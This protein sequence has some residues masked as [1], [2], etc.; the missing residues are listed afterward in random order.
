MATR[1]ALITGGS[2]GLGR[3]AALALADQGHDLIITYRERAGQAEEVASVAR[4]S[5]RKALAL[6]LDVADIAGHGQFAERIASV[7][8]SEWARER[9]DVLVN[10]AGI[11]VHSPFGST[12]EAQFDGLL[13]VH[14]KGPYFLTQALL[15]VIKDGG[16][17]VN[18]STGLTRF[19]IPGYAAYASMKTAMETLSRYWAKELGAR[20]IRVNTIAP[21][22]IETDF[23]A[24]A[25]EHN[26]GLKEYINSQTALGRVGRPDDIGG[27]VAFLCSDAA[28]WVNAQR[29][30]ASGGM[31]L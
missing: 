11:D 22:A 20:R 17:I 27:L 3:A 2:R 25:F 24:P 29:V 14:F 31:F 13:N 26:P 30:E 4:A 23:T 5:G 12:T 9:F 19:S 7:L 15:P 6:P 8:R 28:K 10:N 16:C 21:G 1:I 18:T